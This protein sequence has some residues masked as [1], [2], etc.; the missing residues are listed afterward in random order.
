M[1]VE[2]RGIHNGHSYPVGS[3]GKL[4]SDREHRVGAV[5]VQVQLHPAL[6]CSQGKAT[7]LL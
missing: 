2:V 5:C 7:Q 3:R 4:S 1:P 6:L